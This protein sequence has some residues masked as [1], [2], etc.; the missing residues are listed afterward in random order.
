VDWLGFGVFVAVCLDL[1]VFLA[2][3]ALISFLLV[4]WWG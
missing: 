4:R 2:F 1:L 3:G